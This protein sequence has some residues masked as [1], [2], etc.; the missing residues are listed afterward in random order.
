MSVEL[1]KIA[2]NDLAKYGQAWETIGKGLGLENAIAMLRKEAGLY[3]GQGRDKEA[4]L[5]RKQAERLETAMT[6]NKKPISTAQIAQRE[7]WDETFKNPVE[8]DLATT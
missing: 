2:E 4:S 8:S 7:I 5:I 3:Y 6:A 1:F